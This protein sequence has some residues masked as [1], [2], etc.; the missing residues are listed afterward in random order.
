MSDQLDLKNKIEAYRR[1]MMKAAERSLP[2]EEIKAADARPDP[3]V[4]DSWTMTQPDQPVETV[5][6]P[7]TAENYPAAEA[8][9]AEIAADIRPDIDLDADFAE[10]D[11]VFAEPDNAA[12]PV[13][14]GQN[15]LSVDDWLDNAAATPEAMSVD[16]VPETE[17]SPPEEPARKKSVAVNAEKKQEETGEPSGTLRVRVKLKNRDDPLPGV[18]SVITHET[19]AGPLLMGIVMTGE[20]GKSPAISLPAEGSVPNTPTLYNLYT[21][22]PGYYAVIHYDIPVFEGVDA[23]K[24]VEMSLLPEG[25]A[26]DGVIAYSAGEQE[27]NNA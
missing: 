24:T 1:E 6:A 26:G 2:A 20:D 12:L 8:M 16:L 27:K 3:P 22:L 17:F 4:S 18:T 5:S 19:A 23:Q 15:G 25:Y 10:V 21:V 7:K 14:A 9:Q 11:A 13:N